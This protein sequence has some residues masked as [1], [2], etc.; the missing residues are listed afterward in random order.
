M[1]VNDMNRHEQL[2]LTN[3]ES[4]KILKLNKWVE[5]PQIAIFKSIHKPC[6]FLHPTDRFS[7]CSVL[8]EQLESILILV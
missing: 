1:Q 5:L 4:R 6:N 3:V 2:Q 7:S 8:S